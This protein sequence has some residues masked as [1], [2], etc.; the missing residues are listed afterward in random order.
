MKAGVSFQ[1]RMT[2]YFYTTRAKFGEFSNFSKHGIEADE[3]WWKTTEHYFQAQ[4]FFDEDYREKIRIAPSPKDAANL[5]RSREYPI[6]P[7]WEEVKD[8]VMMFAVEKKFRTHDDLRKLLLST[9]DQ[10]IVEN[11]PGDYYW[12]CGAD[13]SGK[14]MLG[15]I[16][17]EVRGKLRAES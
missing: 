8:S 10:P 13:G 3:K 16:L 12:G 1:K 17:V 9:G 5:G 7:D 15:K 4:K 2:V 6:R 11:A 14:N